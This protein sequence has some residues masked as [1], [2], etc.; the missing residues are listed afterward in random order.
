MTI[1]EKHKIFYYVEI[2]WIRTPD[3]WIAVKADGAFIPR[4]V[5]YTVDVCGG[6]VR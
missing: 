4:C 5:D 3:N 6:F 1:C 2:Q